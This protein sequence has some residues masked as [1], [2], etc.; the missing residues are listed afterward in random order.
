M[1]GRGRSQVRWQE[2]VKMVDRMVGDALQDM[3][4]V[5]FRI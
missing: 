5:E 2:F 1:R 3:A 4:E